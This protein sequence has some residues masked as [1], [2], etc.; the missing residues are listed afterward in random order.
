MIEQSNR[1][2]LA[3]HATTF[4]IVDH[5]GQPWLRLPQIEGALGYQNKGRALATLYDRNA[6][7]FTSSMTALVRLPTA[8]GVQEVRIFSLRGAHLLGMFARTPRAAEFR[9]WVLDVLEADAERPAALAAPSRDDAPLGELDRITR[10]R[11]LLRQMVRVRLL[12]DKPH[13]CRVMHYF[14]VA[15]LTHVERARLMGWSSTS[16]WFKALRELA[17]CGLIDWTP[18]PKRQALGQRQ[19]PRILSLHRAG[20]IQVGRKT[21]T[22]GTAER[23]AQIRQI[24]RDRIDARNASNEQSHV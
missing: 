12:D 19:A 7:E 4:D 23:M 6:A 13:Y 9:K 8:G 22:G 24:R 21:G 17:A 5:G 11:D 15:G 16:P 20:E 10:Q 14:A 18:D 3:F 1:G 2:T